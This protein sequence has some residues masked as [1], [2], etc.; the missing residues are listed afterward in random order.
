MSTT[1]LEET[2]GVPVTVTVAKCKDGSYAWVV[3]DLHLIGQA[4]TMEDIQA[5]VSAGVTDLCKIL[6]SRFDLESENR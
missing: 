5:A 2:A 4:D 3:K 1:V 6:A